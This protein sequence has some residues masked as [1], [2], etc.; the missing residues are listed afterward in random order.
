MFAVLSTR[1]LPLLSG[2][3]PAFSC[4][5]LLDSLWGVCQALWAAF[6]VFLLQ[7]HLIS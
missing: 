3:E 7:L 1:G 4:P 5:S 6:W 2:T